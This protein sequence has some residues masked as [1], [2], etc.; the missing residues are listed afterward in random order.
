MFVLTLGYVGSGKLAF[1]F[2]PQL[3]GDVVIVQA[4]LQPDRFSGEVTI[5]DLGNNVSLSRL[6]SEALRYQRLPQHF[7]AERDEHERNDRQ[8]GERQ[9]LQQF[10][11]L[12][13]GGL[14]VIARHVHAA[15]HELAVHDT[16]GL[17]HQ[18]AGA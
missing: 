1:N 5:W 4:R 2:F 6:T 14:S 15:D 10:R 11:S 12:V 17:L 7:R 18:A 8:R 3:P 16:L 9:L 13:R